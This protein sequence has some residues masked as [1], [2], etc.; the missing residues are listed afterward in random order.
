MPP[1]RFPKPW[2]VEP[3]PN[4]FRVINAN[5][6]VLAHVYG[7]PD[8]AIAASDVRLTNNEARRI[9]KLKKRNQPN[10]GR[11]LSD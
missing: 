5:A 9:S 4:G 8:G 11:L 10:W 3:M 1:R 6:I 2:S 7:Q